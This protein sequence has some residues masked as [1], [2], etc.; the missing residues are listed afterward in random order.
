MK[1]MAKKVIILIFI[2]LMALPF[3][4]TL[5][6]EALTSEEIEAIRTN[7]I[8]DEVLC[9]YFIGA[10]DYAQ[11]FL[12]Q[13]FK[14]EITIDKLVYNKTVMLNANFFN[15]NVNTAKST[16]SKVVREFINTWFSY[17][18]KLALVVIMA[19][20]VGA[21]IKILTNNPESKAGAYESLKKIVMAVMLVFF[22]PYVM[23]YSL[24]FNELLVRKIADENSTN[25]IITP[26]PISNI[27]DLSV[28]EL[29]FRSPQYV[30]IAGLRLGAGSSEATQMFLNR[31]EKYK[32]EVDVMR[33]MRAFAGVTLRPVYVFIWYIMLAQTYILLLT[34]LKRYLL[35]AL[36][37][38][39]YPLVIIGYVV[40]GM[41]GSRQTAFNTWCKEF[42]TN[43][44][45]QTIHAIMYSVISGIVLVQVKG[46]LS[47]LGNQ[48][49]GEQTTNLNV[50][51][52]IVATSFL[53]TGEKM[54]ARFFK[55]TIDT[56]ERA[57]LRKFFRKPKQ[58]L[59]SL[60]GPK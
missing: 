25:A 30:S 60:R 22:F 59:G 6:T 44:F 37:I 55:A 43:V 19:S 45:L 9:P 15:K 53:F 17:F 7:N 48:T 14:E 38:I 10:G 1:N 20:L 8:L 28:D 33:M 40:N 46:Q 32:S 16:A 2:F 23:K 36:L 11:D 31:L 18:Q 26:S 58:I 50:I 41:F 35:I 34:Y 5:A 4:F 42:F 54:L 29:E 12:N 51:L 21:G 13:T 57:G 27:S 39:I 49:R 56:S 24:D 3:N 52:L 47:G